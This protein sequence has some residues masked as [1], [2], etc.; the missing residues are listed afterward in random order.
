MYSRRGSI[1]ET[2]SIDLTDQFSISPDFYSSNGFWYFWFPFDDDD[3]WAVWTCG[4]DR[5]DIDHWQAGTVLADH[6]TGPVQRD[7][8]GEIVSKLLYVVDIG[9]D[10]LSQHLPVGHIQGQGGL[11]TSRVQGS[12]SCLADAVVLVVDK[13][14]S[15]RGEHL[16]DSN[17][18][19]SAIGLGV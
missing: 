5:E 17:E 14:G 12:S 18:G 13:G 6:M 11:V 9:G 19:E 4:Y 10:I 16:A 7:F 2:V 1:G 3:H 8:V 15:G